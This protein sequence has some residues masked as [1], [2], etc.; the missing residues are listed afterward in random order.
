MVNSSFSVG[1]PYNC[2]LLLILTCLHSHNSL[3]YSFNLTIM[4]SSSINSFH[5]LQILNI[6]CLILFFLLV[7]SVICLCVILYLVKR[8]N[9]TLLYC[10]SNRF[11]FFILCIH[12]LYLYLSYHN[13]CCRRHFYFFFCFVHQLKDVYRQQFLHL[14]F[15][16][17][18]VTYLCLLGEVFQH[19]RL[20][21]YTLYLKNH[22]ETYTLQF[23]EFHYYYLPCHL[24]CE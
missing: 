17:F 20:F 11:S 18:L 1:G 19:F 10:L 12:P 7:K 24:E 16:V 13:L 14:R 4:L 3:I 8:F 9:S 6:L 23:Y 2:C 15:F 21:I 22:H 5:F